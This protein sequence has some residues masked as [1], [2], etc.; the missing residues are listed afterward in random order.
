MARERT[1]ARIARYD[2]DLA[3]A[4]AEID[5]LVGILLSA[6]AEVDEPQAMT[7]IGHLLAPVTDPAELAGLL[8]AA[9]W[10]LAGLKRKDAVVNGLGDPSSGTD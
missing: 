2:Q 10:Q 7:T 9:L 5:R 8:A 4:S 1:A 6:L 3:G